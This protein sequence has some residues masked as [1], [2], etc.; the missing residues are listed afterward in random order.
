M[1]IAISLDVLQAGIITTR[2]HAMLTLAGLVTTAL[3]GPLLARSGLRG[4]EPPAERAAAS[5]VNVG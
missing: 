3:A 5:A 2:T 1:T 4:R